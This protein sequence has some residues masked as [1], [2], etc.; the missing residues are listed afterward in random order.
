MGLASLSPLLGSTV[1]Q[2]PRQWLSVQRSGTLPSCDFPALPHQMP[3]VALS[4]P[5]QS[6]PG[7]LPS[8]QTAPASGIF[9]HLRSWAHLTPRAVACSLFVFSLQAAFIPTADPTLCP[10]SWAAESL[11]GSPVTQMRKQNIPRMIVVCFLYSM[12]G[13]RSCQ[14][15]CP[16]HFTALRLENLGSN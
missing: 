11:L 8:H 14:D 1:R 4:C 16:D 10:F 6:S 13:T 2:S 7:S 15:R 5:A 9:T 12:P 3:W